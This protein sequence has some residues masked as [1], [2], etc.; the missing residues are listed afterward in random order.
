[1]VGPH[2]DAMLAKVVAHGD[3]REQAS[4]RLAAALAGARLHGVTTNRDLLVR[5]LRSPAW[6][7]GDVDTSFLQRHDPAE[8]GRPLPDDDGVRLHAAAA[9]LAATAARRADALPA[10]PAG[11]RNVPTATQR[12]AY[13]VPDGTLEVACTHRRGGLAVAVDDVD[14]G[15]VVLHAASG[16]DVDLEVDGLRRQVQVHAVG[17]VT[18][19]DSA[20]GC[21]RLVEVARYPEPGSALVAGSLTAPMP[22]TVVRVAAQVGE[23]V[24][25]GDVLLVLEAMKMEH[26]VRAP[27]DAT[28]EQVS[29]RAGEQVDAGALLVVA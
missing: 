12:T 2:Y 8:L 16:T 15:V 22:G 5:V 11:W 24:A 27:A 17:G 26:A 29:V 9:A 25:A 3:T 7:A 10:V 21:T 19:V 1:M 4:A 18:W 28:V 20:L 14:L 23:V 6:L 13:Q